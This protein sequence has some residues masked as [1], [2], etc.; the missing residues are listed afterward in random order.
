MQAASAE[1]VQLLRDAPAGH[2]RSV[3]LAHAGAESGMMSAFAAEDHVE[4]AEHVA[5]PTSAVGVHAVAMEPA[6]H[7]LV[8]WQAVQAPVSATVEFDQD[9][10]SHAAHEVSA[11]VLHATVRLP[12]VQLEAE[13]EG[14]AL[15]SVPLAE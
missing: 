9:P 1:V 2:A 4:P 14:Q 3:Q 15:A 11:V 10:V 8:D 13:H 7:G 6:E 12:A 5:Q